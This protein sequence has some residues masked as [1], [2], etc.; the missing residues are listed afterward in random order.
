M[1][2]AREGKSYQ[3]KAA[4]SKEWSSPGHQADHDNGH[5]FSSGF[6]V[7]VCI[8]PVDTA[9]YIHCTLKSYQQSSK[10]CLWSLSFPRGEEK[11]LEK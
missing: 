3:G 1:W 11:G 4:E 10:V 2:W 7:C 8:Q 9:L 5:G 6:C